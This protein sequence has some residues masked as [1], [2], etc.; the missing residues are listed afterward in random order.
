MVMPLPGFRRLLIFAI[1]LCPRAGPGEVVLRVPSQYPTIQSA[2]DAIPLNNGTQHR[3]I[4]ISPG[5]YAEAVL[6]P[7]GR[8]HVSLVG[9][10]SAPP[11][12]VIIRTNGGTGN[13]PLTIQ[14]NDV[15][16]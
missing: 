11:G 6:I 12:S 9:D 10:P 4:Q 16:V 13:V 14:A 7:S 15:V 5:L 8:G 3:T 1:L 2:V